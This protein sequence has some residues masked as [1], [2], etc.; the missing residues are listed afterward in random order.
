MEMRIRVPPVFCPTQ[1]KVLK[2]DLI[3]P[4]YIVR[5]DPIDN[6][7]D[8]GISANDKSTPRTSSSLTL[9]SQCVDLQ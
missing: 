9:L 7:G 3:L 4:M 6:D 8:V 5:C 1:R 2:S